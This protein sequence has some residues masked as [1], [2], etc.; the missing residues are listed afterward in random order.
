MIYPKII[1]RI[2][3]SSSIAILS[4]VAPD[5][6][7][8]GSSLGLYNALERT[9]KN[10][11]YILDDEVPRLY[12]FLKNADKVER[13]G[14]WE[15]FDSVVVLDCGEPKLLG[16]CSQYLENNFI[17]NIDHHISNTAYGNLNMVDANAAA[18]G[19]MVYQIIKIMGIPMDQDISECLYTSI[20]TDTGQ[21]QYANTTSV[22]HQIAGDLINNGVSAPRMFEQIY[23]NN[24]KEKVLLMKLALETLEF[25]H[26][27]KVACI[28]MDREKL[29]AAGAKPEDSDGLVN[30]A[31]DI[32]SVEA[33]VFLK[34]L[35]PGKVK[36]GFRSKR[37]VDVCRVAKQFGG[38]G[39]IRAAG[40]TVAGSVDEVKAMVIEAVIKE[41]Q[42]GVDTI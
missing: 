38:G 17:I 16:K 37:F 32:E 25:Y 5:G 36:V 34:E 21:F 41:F 12:R 2:K 13:P 15:A 10:V 30:L 6:D 27:D 14:T 4:H 19:E 22:T 40:C 11:R 28:A 9:G 24:S 20:V 3:D 26:E 39:H 31:R 35:E 8:I 7:N 29:D 23:Q 1:S 42:Q 18:V 33:A